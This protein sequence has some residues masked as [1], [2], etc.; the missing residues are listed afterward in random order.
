MVDAYITFT[1]CASIQCAFNKNTHPRNHPLRNPAWTCKDSVRCNNHLM[2]EHTVYVISN[3]GG[4]L[5]EMGQV[6]G[7]INVNLK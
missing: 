7:H 3:K 5:D 6:E 1:F 4:N 2:Q